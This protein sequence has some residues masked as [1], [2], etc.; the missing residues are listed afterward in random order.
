MTLKKQVALSLTNIFDNPIMKVILDKSSNIESIIPE[1]TSWWKYDLFSR[2]PGPAYVDEDFVGTDLDLSCF[3]FELAERGAVINIP[4][5]KSMRAKS[6]KEGQVVLSPENRHGQV[7]GLSANRDVFSFSLRIKDMNVMSTDKVGDFR[8]YSVTDL[9]GDMYPGFGNL[10]FIPTAM[11]NK[12]LFEN[13][14][15]TDNNIHFKNWVHP[16]RW[17]SLF[18]QYYFIT[19]ALVDRLREESSYYY[20]EIKKMKDEGIQYPVIEAPE[21]WPEKTKEPGKKIKVKSFEVDLSIPDNGS[22]FPTYE[23][24]VKNLVE[25]TNKRKYFTY[26]LVPNLNFAIRTVEYAYYKYG[27][28]RIP[29]WLKNV[30][31]ENNYVAPGKRT[32]WDRVVLFQDQVGQEGVSIKKRVYE[33]TQEVSLDYDN[34]KGKLKNYVAIIL[35]ESG[36]MDSIRDETIG[37]FNQQ[38]ETIKSNSHDMETSVSLVTFNTFVKEPTIWD[39]PESSL[40][41][42]TRSHYRPEGMTALNDAIGYTIE[43]FKKVFDYNDPLTS[44]LLIVLSDGAENAS[45]NYSRDKIAKEI[46]EVQE[47]ERWTV[48]FIGA[49]LDMDKVG[50]QMNIPKGNVAVFNATSRGIKDAGFNVSLGLNSY[51]N[52]RR[53][54]DTMTR[55]FYQNT[56]DSKD[57]KS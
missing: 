47:T 2:K 31:W 38:V 34:R 16:N 52:S 32:K 10:E 12:F 9:D 39:K 22:V 17:S 14:I 29:H 43:R 55:G 36:S 33:T 11:E 19:K 23:H 42:I 28:D 21:E 18:G 13:Q 4:Q 40:S 56:D 44:F 30:A 6:S 35:D 51:Y 41:Q 50:K 20:Q 27:R 48:T 8:N 37:A 46:K 24:N 26:K 53:S 5:Y 15:V 25:L 1:V 45:S 57:S 49:N 7:I 3:L 54:G